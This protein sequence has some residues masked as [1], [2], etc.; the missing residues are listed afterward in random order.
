[1]ARTSACGARLLVDS[2]GIRLRSDRTVLEV[3]GEDRVGWLNGQITNDIRALKPGEAIYALATT[4]KGKVLADLW[5]AATKDALLGFLPAMAAQ[6]VIESFD[7]YLVMEEVELVPRNDLGVICLQ[8][9]AA[10]RMIDTLPKHSEHYP[11][12]DLGTGGYY[13][14]CPRESAHPVMREL[15]QQARG[16]SGGH[17]HP[18]GQAL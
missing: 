11:C 1:M 18:A 3:R 15:A 8:G 14:L 9:P 16:L 4:V 13:V 12:D 17:A 5:V 10:A 7:K 6:A 2:V